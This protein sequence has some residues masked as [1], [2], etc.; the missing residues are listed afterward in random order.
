MKRHFR[1]RP[2]GFTI[3]ELIVTIVLI[4]ILAAIGIPRLVDG[5]TTAGTTFG[6][7][8]LSALRHAQHAA[9]SHRRVVCAE[10]GA[11]VVTLRI[12]SAPGPVA[13][14]RVLGGVE[15]GEYTSTDGAVSVT[16]NIPGTVLFFHPDGTI[17]TSAAG[18][19]PVGEGLLQ[20]RADGAT[21]FEIRLR[22]ETGYVE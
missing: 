1:Q 4:G 20:I 7:Q 15:A 14:D 6:N 2:R 12:A 5:N 8:V 10:F 22:G 3:V 16:D 19:A 17:H 9:A 21:V 11:R 18:N 13:C